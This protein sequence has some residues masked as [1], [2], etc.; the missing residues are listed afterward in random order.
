MNMSKLQK[1]NKTIARHFLFSFFCYKM[2]R[3]LLACIKRSET[4]A[5]CWV[6]FYF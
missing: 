5:F 3:Y 6:P 2:S 1:Y 4:V